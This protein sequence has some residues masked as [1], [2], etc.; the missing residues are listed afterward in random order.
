MLSCQYTLL[1]HTEVYFCFKN[2]KNRAVGELVLH[3]SR[4][5]KVKKRLAAQ[6]AWV[7]MNTLT[8]MLFIVQIPWKSKFF[9]WR[10]VQVFDRMSCGL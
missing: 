8:V 6:T 10:Y 4:K 7:A 3:Q 9:T 1:E 2:I 5:K